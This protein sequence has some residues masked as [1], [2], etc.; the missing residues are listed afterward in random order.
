MK[1]SSPLI[2]IVSNIVLEPFEVMVIEE[3]VLLVP[4]I[5][6]FP[7]AMAIGVAELPLMP[8]VLFP[9]KYMVLLEGTLIPL[10]EEALRIKLLRTSTFPDMNVPPGGV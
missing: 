3:L 2:P 10:N 4:I 7:H 9:C 5:V 1:I 6:E 8:M